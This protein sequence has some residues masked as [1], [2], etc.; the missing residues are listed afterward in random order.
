MYQPNPYQ[1][2]TLSQQKMH[3]PRQP[4]PK[5]QTTTQQSSQQQK[6]GPGN[7]DSQVYGH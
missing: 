1:N 3:N 7:W 2:P 4:D 5:Q 6:Q